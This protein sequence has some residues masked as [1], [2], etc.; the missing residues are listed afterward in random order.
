[1]RGLTARGSAAIVGIEGRIAG[2]TCGVGL[3]VVVEGG[4]YLIFARV[5][6]PTVQQTTSAMEPE[7]RALD[8]MDPSYCSSPASVLRSSSA[9]FLCL[10]SQDVD[11]FP[12]LSCTI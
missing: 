2:E 5:F 7:T 10:F 3:E 12:K 1:M 6:V 11:I 4:D 9:C 8:R